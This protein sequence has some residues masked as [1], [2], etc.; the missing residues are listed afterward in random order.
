MHSWRIKK[1]ATLD[2]SSGNIVGLNL[3]IKKQLSNPFPI[4]AN[5]SIQQNRFL[6]EQNKYQLLIIH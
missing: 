4:S 3:S 6:I 1:K 5:S 2:F